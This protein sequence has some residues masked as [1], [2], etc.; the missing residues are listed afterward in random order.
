MSRYTQDTTVKHTFPKS[1]TLAGDCIIGLMNRNKTSKI[2]GERNLT[3]RATWALPISHDVMSMIVGRDLGHNFP[4]A[5]KNPAIE[6]YFNK[7][8]ARIG[9]IGFT[10]FYGKNC[11]MCLR[12]A[13]SAGEGLAQDLIYQV[14]D[15]INEAP[16]SETGA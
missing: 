4:D 1:P 9:N 3:G 14:D 2:I 10:L 13:H 6:Q 8:S 5:I 15:F 7:V 11:W 12:G 16:A